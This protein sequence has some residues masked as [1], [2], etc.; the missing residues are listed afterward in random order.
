[1]NVF[2]L[3]D[4][5]I[6][7]YRR[8]VTSFLAIRD[9]RIRERVENSLTEGRL[10]PEPRV[11][12]NPAFESGGWVDDLVDEGLLHEACRT[13]FRVS[14]RADAGDTKTG[15]MRLYRHQVDAIREARAGRNYVL[16]TG[17]GSGKSLA[18]MVPIVDHVLRNG[19]GRGIQAI[20]V[21]PMNA[22]ANSQAKELEKFLGVDG[23]SAPV[24]VARYTGQESR[25]QRDAILNNPPDVLLTNYVML[26]LILTR[27]R[28]REHLVQAAAGLRFLV[29]DELHT[30]RG[31]QGAD[32]A[33]L[34]RRLRE[35]CRATQMQCVGTSA[36][37]STEGSL[38]DQRRA[39]AD[40]ATL[41]FGTK[42]EP[43]SVIGETLRRATTSADRT[44]PPVDDL[45]ER[46]LDGKPPQ[47]YEELVVDPLAVWLEDAFGVHE[48]EGR[49]VRVSP[50]PIGGTE[51]GA[52]T[53]S[54]LIG[55]DRER[56]AGAIKE[57]LMAGHEI[58]NPETGFP[59][60]AFRL[61][62][63][64]SKGDTVFAS[65]EPEAQR[66]LTLNGQRFVPGHR[67]KVLLP[68]SFCRQCG[69]EYYT[70]SRR[71]QDDGDAS[72][73]E[74]RDIGERVASADTA[75]GFLYLSTEHPWPSD[76]EEV[77]ARVPEDWIDQSATTPR[78]TSTAKK[79]QP[80]ALR[81]DSAGQVAEHGMPAWWMP[82][83]F[84][85]CMQCGV[86]Y[87][88]AMRSDLSKLTTLGSEGRSTATT[89]LSLSVVRAL[90]AD[91]SIPA[92]A[93]KLLSFTDNRQDASLQAGHCN[94]FVEV[95]LLRHAVYQAAAQAGP[96][97][98]EHE[99]L[100]AAVFEALALPFEHFAVDP[101][102]EF[103]AKADTERALRDV[104]GYHVYLD[105]KRGWRV[106]SPNLEQVGL[107][108][109]AYESL[110]DVCGA[111]HIWADKHLSLRGA[112]PKE[113]RY[114]AH[115]LLDYLRREL[116]IKVD[117]LDRNYLEQ[118]QQRSSQRLVGPWALDDVSQLEYA[119]TVVPRSQQRGDFRGW[120]YLSARSGFGRLLR[121]P[122]TFA[123]GERL[124]MDD[125][126]K[127]ILDLFAGLKR[128]GLVEETLTAADGT[129]GYQVPASALRWR[130]GDGTRPFVDPVRMPTAPATP[131]APND[132]F[133][134]LYRTGA[135]DLM[136]VEA[137]EHTAQVKY[138][139][140]ERREARFR[141]A[142][143][144]ILY[145]S[146]TMELGVDIAELNVVNLRNVPPTPAN[147]AQRSGRAG[148][149]GQPALVFTYCAAG[150]PHDQWFFRRPHLM[151]SGQVTTPRIDL[152]NEDL[153]RSHIQAVWLAE[154]GLSLGSSLKDVLDVG[155]GVSD[156]Q[157]LQRVRD[158]LA[159]PSSRRRAREMA[160]LVL[161][162]L[163]GVLDEASWWSDDWLDAVLNALSPSFEQ[164]TQ[165]WRTLYRSASGQ[166]DAQNAIIR[167]ASTSAT[168][169]AAARRLR[170]EAETQLELLTA[171]ADRRTQSDFYSYRYFAAEGFLP[172]YSFPRLPL[173][174]FIPS[175]KGSH[176]DGG[177]ISR[178]RFLAV[179][180]FGPRSLVYH[181]G[182]RFEVNRVI[183]PVGEERTAE[184]EPLLTTEMKRCTTCGYLHPLQGGAAPD[185][186]DRCKKPLPLPMRGLF[187]L[188]NVATRRRDRISSDEEERQR[189]GFELWSG[190]R[191][192]DR[193]GVPSSRKADVT[194]PTAGKVATMEYGDTA[195]LWR[196][197]L[198][199]RRRANQDQR[200]FLLDVDRG[201][202]AKNQE[203]EGEGGADDPM[204]PRVQR[205]IPY[206]EDR[207]NCLL[208]EPS[209]PLEKAEMASLE[210]DA[211]AV[212]AFP[213]HVDRRG[214]RHR[215]G[216][217]R[218][219]APQGVDLREAARL[220]GGDRV[221]GREQLG[222][223]E[224]HA[225]TQ[226]DGG[227]AAVVGEP[228]LPVGLE[229]VE[230]DVAAVD[231]VGAPVGVD[232]AEVRGLLGERP[233][234]VVH[235]GDHRD[236]GLCAHAD[237]E[238]TVLGQG[239]NTCRVLGVGGDRLRA[240]RPG[241]VQLVLDR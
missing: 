170:K 76:T 23:S 7:D 100:P 195:T 55:I 46:I 238:V 181:E 1:M 224:P 40:M 186:C 194:H 35:A 133:V 217:R 61:H 216:P 42:V 192:A 146:P 188:Q 56:C 111:E 128:A 175:H 110:D 166:F 221:L 29:L 200:G 58:D 129:P 52:E 69:Q 64:I 160:A 158:D 150:S 227:L 176:D 109:I 153:V 85:L 187:R 18:Y 36:T 98:V 51:G 161:G 105:L 41:L 83:P 121:R 75:P 13:I 234:V 151:V 236:V 22:L 19:K 74:T 215:A 240:V 157:L 96:A 49:L 28:E 135:R 149:S 144:P 21:Y 88:G 104:L 206:V 131:P 89:V 11:G 38:E 226:S 204:G 16:T 86:S 123:G 165:R 117:Y 202:W 171:D 138:E 31:R 37:L 178:P 82:A 34:V 127:V 159:N 39:V 140:R 132:F 172:G 77:L 169:K 3:R 106:T 20:V 4:H 196:L 229:D 107:L 71:T 219:P 101:E 24:R 228:D 95:S 102:L 177:F 199:R 189:Q 30:Y 141:T 94:D 12:L 237:R 54:Q 2:E 137:R 225:R 45:I 233:G 9:P 152:A 239:G 167:N 136:G 26:E 5:L 174:A 44:N 84:R 124:S 220:L 130:V 43:R 241:L 145:C 198:G 118:L 97:G 213:D 17:T 113:R 103:A 93:R 182:A 116:A 72:R 126:S 65:V 179:S 67:D 66:H 134:E 33:L 115:I 232:I 203:E 87:G 162:D 53:L 183:L 163:G 91:P 210:S 205:V 173:S 6:D 211:D 50:R 47:T 155:E 70:V 112:S 164:A 108:E 80:V 168:D 48:E 147:Y 122:T 212:Q 32:V 59:A 156:P 191:F 14:T 79:L 120:S 218:H 201:Y 197:N 208:I 27:N 223:V 62:Q 78:L 25:E 139:E 148:R 222:G 235:Q 185:L 8:Y 73:F 214:Y 68:L 10:W 142:D 193:K 114:V 231:Q 184:G 90:R 125:T 57:W 15:R 190:V 60:F 209:Q 81:V 63:F 119:R 207:R 92:R 143:L 99:R 154:S 230:E 180:E